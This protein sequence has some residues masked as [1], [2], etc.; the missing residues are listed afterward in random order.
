MCTRLAT[1]TPLARKRHQCNWCGQMIDPGQRYER[2]RYV[3]GPEAWTLRLHPE[4]SDALDE[5]VRY[6][7]G[8]CVYF[9]E[10]NEP[11]GAVAA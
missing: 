3:N 4:C 11:R 9:D 2:Q 10:F 1:E 6:E 5:A 8:G 7:G